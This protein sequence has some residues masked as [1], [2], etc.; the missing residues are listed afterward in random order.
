[1]MRRARK[2]VMI[3]VLLVGTVAMPAAA[4]LVPAFSL[5][6]LTLAAADVIHGDVIEAR[7]VYDPAFGRIYTHTDVRV[8]GVLHSARGDDAPRHG[9]VI[10]VRQMG[11]VLYGLES[12]VVGNASLSPGAGV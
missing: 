3:G 10:T 11:G 5:R 6:H 7:A 9:E 1:M 12:R 4:T 8:R 2:A